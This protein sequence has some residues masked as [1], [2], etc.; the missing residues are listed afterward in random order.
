MLVISTCQFR[1]SDIHFPKM[2]I[3]RWLSMCCW[4][5]VVLVVLVLGAPCP[6]NAVFLYSEAHRKA[7]CV[8][9]PGLICFGSECSRGSPDNLPSFRQDD[10]G[11]PWTCATCMCGSEEDGRKG[12]P[13]ATREQTMAHVRSQPPGRYPDYKDAVSDSVCLVDDDSQHPPRPLRNA[14]W[15][16]FP[17]CGTSFTS[18]LYNY[19]CQSTPQSTVLYEVTPEVELNYFQRTCSFCFKPCYPGKCVGFSTWSPHDGLVRKNVQKQGFR[20]KMCAASLRGIVNTHYPLTDKHVRENVRALAMFR[21][22][23]ARLKS[24]YNHARHAFGIGDRQAMVDATRNASLKEWAHYPGIAACQTKML[25]GH[26]CASKAEV[27]SFHLCQEA[28]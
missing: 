6:Q 11:F 19:V 9:S 21:N 5:L 8:C 2:E 13:N 22:P 25:N 27:T 26:H 18:V 20:T 15:I 1:Q 16:H 7:F 24:A 3:V 12:S 14:T 10:V 17:K 28:R 4:L 23:L